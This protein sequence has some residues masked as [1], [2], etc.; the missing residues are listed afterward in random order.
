MI[1]IVLQQRIKKLFWKT[2]QKNIPMLLIAWLWN[3]WTQYEKTRHNAGFLVVD[4]LAEFWN[5]ESWNVH[6]ESKS[7]VSS[8]V[9]EW[10]KVLLIKP[11]TYMNRSWTGVGY[12][13]RY[14][15]IDLSDILVIHDDID[16]PPQRLK[17]KKWGSSWGQNGINDIIE[18]LGTK[19]FWRLK[20]G[21]WRSVNPKFDV[22][23]YVLGKMQWDELAFW[24]EET[25]KFVEKVQEW[26]RNR[27]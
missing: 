13:Q 16:L 10:E 18:K 26:K 4:R 24:E 21:I 2:D 22:K 17:L 23:D 11:Q 3:P 20:C 25:Q 7:L 14:Y 19:E 12:R 1:T 27:K 6:R 8:C 5:A 15:T 9:R